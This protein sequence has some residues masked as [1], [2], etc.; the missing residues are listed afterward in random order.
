MMGI[1][2]LFTIDGN[3]AE[4]VVCSVQSN[5]MDYLLYIIIGGVAVIAL[6]VIFLIRHGKKKKRRLVP[7][8]ED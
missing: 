6:I 8:M 5:I 1:Y 4:I 2:H 7:D 3:E